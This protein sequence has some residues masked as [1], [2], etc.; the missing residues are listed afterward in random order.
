[1]Q[2]QKYKINIIDNFLEIKLYKRDLDFEMIEN[3]N[4]NVSANQ[5]NILIIKKYTMKLS[6][7]I[8]YKNKKKNMINIKQRELVVIFIF[9][10]IR[11]YFKMEILF[12]S[13]MKMNRILIIIITF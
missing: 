11:K 7:K 12:T 13:L 4:L 8:I 10:L 5:R 1:M 6:S 2:L 9:N 3:I